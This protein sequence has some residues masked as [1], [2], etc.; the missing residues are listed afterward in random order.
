[1]RIKKMITIL[2]ASMMLVTFT[3]PAM[4][5][6]GIADTPETAITLTTETNTFSLYTNGKG[7]DDWFAWT[8]NTG[9]MKRL[10]VAV[11]NGTT[12]KA[13][14]MLGMRI[15]Y[16]HGEKTSL[17][18]AEKLGE[19]NSGLFS[20]FLIPKGA[21]IYFV[22]KAKEYSIEQYNFL[23]SVSNATDYYEAQR[24]R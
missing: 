22:V 7:D 18:Y 4:A 3:Q 15:Q 14:L 1:M 23:F 2:F 10:F 16:K 6:T 20:D 13:G 8:N 11:A 17:V 24:S 19:I 5:A 21:T 12:G 9:E